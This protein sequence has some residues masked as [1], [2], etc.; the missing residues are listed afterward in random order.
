MAD[1]SDVNGVQVDVVKPNTGKWSG[2]KPKGPQKE[3]VN[4]ASQ[5]H[6]ASQLHMLKCTRCGYQHPPK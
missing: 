4:Q 6:M 2:A 3:A 5:S 1:K